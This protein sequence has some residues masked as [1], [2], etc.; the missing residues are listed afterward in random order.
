MIRLDHL[1][2]TF[3][4]RPALHELSLDIP[5][6]QIFGLLG[7]NGAGKSTTFG[8][9]LGQVHPTAG[10]AFIR[11]ISVQRHRL[12]ALQGVGAIFE[13]PAFYDYLSGWTNLRIFT[14]Y[15]R[16]LPDSELL[17]TVKFV[18]LESR[19]HD[20][21]RVYSHGMRQRLALAQALLP[22]PEILLLDEPA[23]GLDPEGIHEMRHLILRLNREHG[24]TVLLSS[25]LL[26][27]VEQ[28]CDRIAVLNQGRMIFQGKW[29]D[30]T[31][32]AP[33]FR[34]EADPWDKAASFIATRPE[35]TLSP[36]R[37]V[38]VAPGHDVADLV[39]AL[40]QAG[41]KIR[42]VEPMKQNLEEIYLDLIG[43]PGRAA[44]AS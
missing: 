25:H 21:V 27:E 8:M 15:T 35:L 4:S 44:H 9:I 38:T 14:S 33:R 36:D 32:G 41:I 43:A 17:E 11:D 39:A 3:G 13:T 16:R 31:G 1:S 18:G 19:I 5:Q 30:L 22:R 2:K 40:V 37:I 34:L 24:M 23:E 42:A 12:R 6:G 20:H 10:M 7:H 28:L 29:T 26:A